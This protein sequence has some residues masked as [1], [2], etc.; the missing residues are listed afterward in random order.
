[1]ILTLYLK[2]GVISQ[3]PQMSLYYTTSLDHYIYTKN[4]KKN[5]EL[6]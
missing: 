5:N 4:L 3:F 1:M 2:T 6:L